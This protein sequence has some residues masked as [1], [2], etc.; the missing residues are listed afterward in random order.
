MTSSGSLN[1]T[2]KPPEPNSFSIVQ[3]D[4]LEDR[5]SI[6]R[7][8]EMTRV[9]QFWETLG[10]TALIKPAHFQF[11]FKDVAPVEQATRRFFNYDMEAQ[12]TLYLEP[13]QDEE[14]QTQRLTGFWPR[15]TRGGKRTR[16]GV[17]FGDLIFNDDRQL[18]V[19]IKPHDDDRPGAKESCLRDY[20]NNLAAGELGFFSLEPV[21]FL[22]DYDRSY[23]ITRLQES[24]TTLDSID[25]S[26]F[27][28]DTNDHPGMM[29]I[30][31]QV[32]RRLADLHVDGSMMHGDLAARNIAITSD[33]Q[34]FFID[35]EFASL[36]LKEPR[37]VEVKFGY[38]FADLDLLV[39][40]MCMPTTQGG[41]GIF[42]GK[43]GDWWKG[44][45]DFF[46]DEYEALR[47]D[48]VKGTKRQVVVEEEIQ[49]LTRSLEESFEMHHSEYS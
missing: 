20:T 42:S 13:S 40:C 33:S 3:W 43:A 28:P 1:E 31:S 30:W 35:W 2:S 41:I 4:G 48:A 17:F 23:S 25:W 11:D 5:R 8:P 39:A 14:L 16:H 38:S 47:L 34:V 21:G 19:A 9:Y 44:F 7:A 36:D 49:E 24:L 22:L 12:P 6:E 46:F 27:Y 15:V 10:R 45:C 29:Q 18:P 26:N 32:A 37:D